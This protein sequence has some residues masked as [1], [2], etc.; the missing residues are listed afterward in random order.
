MA[1]TH[2]ASQNLCPFVHAQTTPQARKEVK[3][4][5]HSLAAS[6]SMASSPARGVLVVVVLFLAGSVSAFVVRSPLCQPGSSLQAGR[7]RT[8]VLKASLLHELAQQWPLITLAADGASMQ[9]QLPSI[10]IE[11]AKALLDSFPKAPEIPANILQSIPKL[12]LPTELP[13]QLQGALKA[14][15]DATPGAID[16]LKNFAQGLQGTV[17]K[18]RQGGSVELPFLSSLPSLPSV[19]VDSI[20]LSGEV[21]A[22]LGAL[23]TQVGDAVGSRLSGAGAVL[24][25]QLDKVLTPY[26]PLIDQTKSQLGE[27][28]SVVSKFAEKATKE[29]SKDAETLSPALQVL[30]SVGTPR[31]L[32]NTEN[33]IILPFW[34]S[35]ILAPNNGLV[36]RLM[37][38]YI[39]VLVAALAYT[40]SAYLAFQ[41]PAALEGFASISDITGLG[42][43]LGSEAGTATAWAHFIAQD[44]FVGRWIYLD[45]LRNGVWT[46]HSLTLA[47]LFGPTG[48]LS[49]LATRSFV[50]VFRW[51]VVDIMTAGSQAVAPSA[52]EDMAKSMIKD[53]EKQSKGALRAADKQ[54]DQVL[55]KAK[56]EA[57]KIVVEARKQAEGALA[58][59][60]KIMANAEAQAQDILADAQKKAD[61]LMSKAAS[62]AP[63]AAAA[64]AP[65]PSP[66]P[67]VGPS[68]E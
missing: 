23:K 16:G 50:K 45:G 65:G 49:H 31:N 36:K 30:R 5:F 2:P 60:G 34:L 52:A 24:S 7:A 33:L 46:A 68:R 12:S 62:A 39:P 41:D 32:F 66:R 11:D 17:E 18:I 48:I 56:A 28:F 42:K 4:S 51:D 44:L 55:K 67:T 22:Q 57:R 10:N 37:S 38:S 1:S 25:E 9:D 21:K 26:Q 15:Q 43:G 61:T 19:D 53:A 14:A 64:S 58:S 47:F 3:R 29:L 6:S 54:A 20:P 40:W 63:P 35:V 27:K 8:H 59:E 13:S